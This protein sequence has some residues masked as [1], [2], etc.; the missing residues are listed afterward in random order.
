M[1][2]MERENILIKHIICRNQCEE[3]KNVIEKEIGKLGEREETKILMQ[4]IYLKMKNVHREFGEYN[5]HVMTVLKDILVN[6]PSRA[7][8]FI[9][10]DGLSILSFISSK[11]LDDNSEFLE[12][13]N[14]L[15]IDLCIGKNNS[16]LLL[17]NPL[18]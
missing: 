1:K 14:L 18:L 11:I 7:S 4:M 2:Q 16:S 3:T 13:C 9:Q 10:N 12:K 15:F 5:Y 17:G 8:L 6:N